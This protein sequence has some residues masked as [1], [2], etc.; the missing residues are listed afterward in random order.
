MDPRSTGGATNC[1]VAALRGFGG[2]A[3]RLLLGPHNLIEVVMA[4]AKLERASVQIS[5]LALGISFLSSGFAVYQWWTTGTDEKIRATIDVSNKYIEEAIDPKGLQQQYDI[6]RREMETGS[7]TVLDVQKADPSLRIRKHYSRLE[8]ISYLANKG[9]L[10]LGYLSQFVVCDVIRAPDD[11]EEVKK[12]RE[13]RKLT[14]PSDDEVDEDP[15]K[16]PAKEA[17]PTKAEPA[18]GN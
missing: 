16:K 13:R 3:R 2:N 4:K 10:D 8:Y 6:M 17:E 12:F 5:A 1:H 15:T 9:K 18:K 14:C 11:L 7:R